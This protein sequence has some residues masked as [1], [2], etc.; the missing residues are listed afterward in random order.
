MRYRP[1]LP[2]VFAPLVGFLMGACLA[3]AGGAEIARD[4]GPIVAT[5]PFALIVAFALLIYTP[6]VGYFVTFH[7]DWAYLYLVPWRSVPSA[8]DLALVLASGGA[9]VGGHLAA[10]PFLRKRRVG[11]VVSMAVVPG[12]ITLALLT[13]G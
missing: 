4:D 13:L 6:L 5:R 2:I 11:P 9:M 8:I 7:G 10:V 3:W 12:T 1:R